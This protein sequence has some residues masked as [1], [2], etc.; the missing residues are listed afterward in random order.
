M[1]KR[2]ILGC[3]LLA[4]A[5]LAAWMLWPR[6]L[7]AEFDAGQRFAATVTVHGLEMDGHFS[8]PTSESETY[9]VEAGSPESAAV[10][11]VL[12]G[13]SYHLCL[14]SLT[15]E[16]CIEDIGEISIFLSNDAGESLHVFSGT[17]K[18]SCNGRVVR[19]NWGGK[20]AAALCAGLASAL[21][22]E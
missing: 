6:P 10:R 20:D 4:A 19:L 1:K 14:D 8:H 11:A 18:L 15:G 9:T 5:L 16:D 12:E 21:G 13:A 3:A 17:G 22:A 7:A 2:R